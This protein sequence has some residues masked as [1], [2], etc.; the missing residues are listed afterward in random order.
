MGR[1]NFFCLCLNGN[2][3]TVVMCLVYEQ[4]MYYNAMPQNR[5]EVTVTPRHNRVS[6]VIATCRN[7]LD[8]FNDE[9]SSASANSKYKSC[10]TGVVTHLSARDMVSIRNERRG[11]LVSAHSAETFIGFIKLSDN[12]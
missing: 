8:Y 2:Y 12:H 4:L 9:T 1:T 11:C 7:S 6:R 3:V 10:Y 5:Y